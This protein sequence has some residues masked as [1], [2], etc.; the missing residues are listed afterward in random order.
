[1][2]YKKRK[3]RINCETGNGFKTFPD[4]PSEV[5]HTK[6]PCVYGKG[7]PMCPLYI[8]PKPK[9]AKRSRS[10]RKTPKYAISKLHQGQLNKLN[11][12]L[13]DKCS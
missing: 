10:K 1:M 7:K 13:N 5:N 6:P 12:I 4:C 8:L 2:T 11:D 9:N 3:E